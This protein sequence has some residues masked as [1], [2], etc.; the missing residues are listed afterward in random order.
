V[1]D[2][3]P[4]RDGVLVR[5]EEGAKQFVAREDI[6]PLEEFRALKAKAAQG[7]S[8]NES[9]GCDCGSR[10]PKSASG[11]LADALEAAHGKS[12][13]TDATGEEE[14]KVDDRGRQR[15]SRRRKKRPFRKGKKSDD[16]GQAQAN[17]NSSE[18]KASS[19]SKSNKRKRRRRKRKKRNQGNNNNNQ[20]NN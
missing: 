17:K 11:D 15:T 20:N 6:I 9:G 16:D 19:Q 3:Y 7:C 8:K 14:K 18:Q 13:S 10:R 5:Y 2:I 1:I 4:L 12:I